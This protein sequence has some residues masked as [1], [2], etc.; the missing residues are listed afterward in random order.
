LV[1]STVTDGEWTL[2]YGGE[3]APPELYHLPSAPRQERKVM[4]EHPEVATDLHRRHL[5]LLE[6]L[7]RGATAPAAL[8]A[9]GPLTERWREDIIGV[10]DARCKM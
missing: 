4:A 5:A 3:L 7:A 1:Y 10:Q 9:R 8:L 2:V 6:T